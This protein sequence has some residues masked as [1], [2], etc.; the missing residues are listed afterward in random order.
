MNEK[1][2]K[3][4]ALHYHIFELMQKGLTMAKASTLF[5]GEQLEAA[6]YFDNYLKTELNG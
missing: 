3:F 6:T 4:W 1:V 2:T 5:A